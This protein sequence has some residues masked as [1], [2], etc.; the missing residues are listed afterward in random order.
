MNFKLVPA[1]RTKA[2]NKFTNAYTLKYR[3]DMVYPQKSSYHS[4]IP[5]KIFQTWHTKQLPP[6]MQSAV[7][8]IKRTNPRFSHQLFDDND[9]REFIKAHFP[10]VVLEAFDSLLPGAYKADLWRYCVLYKEGGIYLDI[11]YIPHNKFR[12]ITLTE[13]EHFVLDADGNGVYNA[14]MVCKPENP[15]L[16]QAIN[17]IIRNVKRRYYGNSSL[18]IT[19]PH[20]LSKFLPV[21]VKKHFSLKHEVYQNQK[22]ITLNGIIVLKM[23]RNYYEEMRKTEKNPHYNILWNERKVYI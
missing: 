13:R 14:L 21:S 19:G 1:R 3:W 2:F 23:Y 17:A 18:E 22:L 12:F 10:P 7:E 9:C 6:N 8:M 15:I 5:L 16:F 20:L 4:I 11:K